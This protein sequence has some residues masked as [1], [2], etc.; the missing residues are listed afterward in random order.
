MNHHDPSASTMSRIDPIARLLPL[1]TLNRHPDLPVDYFGDAPVMF[2]IS[3]DLAHLPRRS[4]END[5]EALIRIAVELKNEFDRDKLAK[6]DQCRIELSVLPGS[7]SVV[8][9]KDI[10]QTLLV[11]HKEYKNCD[12]MSNTLGR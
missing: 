7:L 8:A 10:Y 3:F 12:G 11:R 2:D 6:C 5:H 1:M 4:G 9:T